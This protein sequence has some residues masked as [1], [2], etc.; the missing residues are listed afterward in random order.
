MHSSPRAQQL[1]QALQTAAVSN[2]KTVSAKAIAA[3]PPTVAQVAQ[4]LIERRQLFPEQPIQLLQDE[5]LSG[6]PARIR[7]QAE[8]I[9]P[10][11]G[12]SAGIVITLEDRKA[13]ASQRAL[14]DAQR[15]RLTQRETEVWE[16]SLL[17]LSYA[18]V[19]QEL[20]ISLNTVKRHM[21]NIRGKRS[22]KEG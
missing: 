6:T 13:I 15:Y 14:F 17:G 3:L 2:S 1:C 22:L 18:Q 7:V 10:H 19:A 21:K 8:W 11:P 9:D 20:F 16:L 12:Q 4:C 5:S